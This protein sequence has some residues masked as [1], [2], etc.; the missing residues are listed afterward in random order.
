MSGLNRWRGPKE[1][2]YAT[3]MKS[4]RG[5]EE[6]LQRWNAG[7]KTLTLTGPQHAVRSGIM[8]I[9]IWSVYPG[10][11]EEGGGGGEVC[12]F[13]SLGDM[14]DARTCS[15]VK[16]L[17]SFA[18]IPPALIPTCPNTPV[19]I[20]TRARTKRFLQFHLQGLS[21]INTAPPRFQW[22]SFQNCASAILK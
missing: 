5:L 14:G 19:Q 1:V 2:T 7:Y 13:W 9:L 11:A 8:P 4:Q 10:H 21:G 17:S 6:D 12:P 3:R 20:P 18:L 16:L 22:P 15:L